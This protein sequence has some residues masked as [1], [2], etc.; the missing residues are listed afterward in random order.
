MEVEFL[1]NMR[2]TLYASE[3][4]WKAWHKKLGIFSEYYDKASRVQ[5]GLPNLTLPPPQFGIPRDLPTPPISTNSSPPFRN[6]ST[7]HNPTLPHPLSMPPYLAQSNQSPPASMPETDLSSWSRKRSL[8]EQFEP[9][10]KRLNS[11]GPSLASSNTLTPT[12]MQNT[13]PVP[14]LPM[15]NL[16]VSTGHQHHGYNN[17]P[18]QLVP[19]PVSR[20]MSAVYAA[21]TSRSQSTVQLPSLQPTNYSNQHV[22]GHRPAPLEFQNR[23]TPF[24]SAA[25]TPSPTSYHFPQH[26]PNGVSP[27]GGAAPRTSP[28]KP[29]RSVNTLLVPPPSASIQN[30][31]QNVSFGQMH[32]QPLGKPSSERRTGVLPYFPFDTTTWSQPNHIQHH[33]PQPNFAS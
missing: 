6:H 16:S 19:I 22:N 23:Q 12:T 2:Y 27:S 17:S 30:H 15:P 10:A 11:L 21:P 1:S 32:Y 9:P 20:A 7:V 5:S 13:P 29:I 4:D 25:S 3:D 26:T 33:L 28:Y 31:P 24:S 18:A 14:R 8:E